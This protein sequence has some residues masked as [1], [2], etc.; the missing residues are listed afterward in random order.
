MHNLTPQIVHYF[1]EACFSI[2]TVFSK[3]KAEADPT[4]HSVSAPDKAKLCN[5]WKNK[6]YAS[7]SNKQRSLVVVYFLVSYHK[8]KIVTSPRKA[9]LRITRGGF[10]VVNPHLDPKWIHI[11][12]I[13]EDPDPYSENWS[14]ST[15]LQKREKRLEWLN[16]FNVLL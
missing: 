10:C 4:Q 12:S 9:K 15:Q 16:K 7:I 13:F 14:G 11:F 8:L 2:K 3:V 1:Y 6:K 5:I